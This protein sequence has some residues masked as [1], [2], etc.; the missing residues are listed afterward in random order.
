V[1]YTISA[2][3]DPAYYRIEQP[4]TDTDAAVLVLGS[5]AGETNEYAVNKLRIVNDVLWHRQRPWRCRLCDL[6]RAC[7]VNAGDDR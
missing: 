1:L 2:S 7:R 5:V 3:A 4:G 6:G